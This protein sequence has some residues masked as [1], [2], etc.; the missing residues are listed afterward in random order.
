M[1]DTGALD[2]KMGETFCKFFF[3]FAYAATGPHRSGLR[4]Y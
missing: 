2:F 4:H 1:I 3:Q